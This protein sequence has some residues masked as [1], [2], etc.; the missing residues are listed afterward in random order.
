MSVF[1]LL[2]EMDFSDN[3]IKPHTNCVNNPIHIWIK[4]CPLYHPRCLYL[5]QSEI[6]LS[7]LPFKEEV[8]VIGISVYEEHQYDFHTHTFSHTHTSIKLKD[9]HCRYV[10]H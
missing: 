10:Q 4:F 2:A 9:Q 1:V 6:N 8:I 7:H 5:S 3:C